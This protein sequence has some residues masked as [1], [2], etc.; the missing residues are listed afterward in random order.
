MLTQMRKGA[1]SWPSKI[2]LGVIALSFVGWGV[3][4]I[5]IN[6][7]E[8]T[9]AQVGDTEIDVFDLE[10]AYRTQIRQFQ[11]SGMQVEPGS[12]FARA[13]ANLSL[14]QLI[15]DTLEADNARAMGVTIAEDTLRADIAGNATFFNTEG[16]FD[17]AVFSGTLATSGL[18]EGRYL[19]ILTNQL[20]QS[21][22]INSIG[23]VPPP[24]DTLVDR[25]FRHRQERRV[26][27]IAVI[28]ND[29]LAPDPTPTDSALATYFAEHEQDYAAPE[30]R[31]ADYILVYPEDLATDVVIDETAV[32]EAYDSSPDAWIDPEQR[33][34]HQIPFE[35]KDA[36][37]AAYEL[38]RSG[39]DFAQVA[40]DSAG[41]DAES[42][43]LGWFTRVDL[44]AELSDPI[45]AVD[46]GEVVAPIESPLGGW[47][48][49]RVADAKAEQ[50]TPFE[51]AQPQIE[52]ALKLRAARETIFDLANDMDDIVASGTSVEETA[53][54]LQ[55]ERK[56]VER[57]SSIGQP[58][59]ILSLQIIPDAR[60]F[61]SELFF[62][63]IDFPSP[64]IETNDGGLLVVEVTAIA[65]AR[66]RTLDEVEDQVLVDWQLAEQSRLAQEAAEATA[67]AAGSS[68]DLAEAFETTFEV[69]EPF[70]RNQAPT[71]DN[72][73]LDTVEALFSASPGDTVVV[74]SAD[75]TAQVIAR[76]LDVVSGDPIADSEGH[77]AVEQ[78]LTNGLI[79]DVVDQ[80][81][82][83]M[84]N[85]TDVN[86]DED[87]VEQ[88]F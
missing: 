56:M 1:S 28:S 32:R 79:S 63:D 83:A 77:I 76:L 9:V 75:G 43:E 61:L 47:L 26:A 10:V 7:G 44:F 85:E 41:I 54:S 4:D 59:D 50:V 33:L 13:L 16:V 31:S 60:E 38:V 73:G 81:T 19:G 8:T 40:F 29:T 84:F 62:G 48:L 88:Y 45:F 55:L 72:V 39:S 3:G 21:Q 70:Q 17:P 24:P 66:M 67:A 74:N 22:Y 11:D 58:E 36:A 82:A 64:V 71:L 18:S 42:L 68:G 6:R 2:L 12:D 49:L 34:L 46:A 27:E 53:A 15:N 5:F 87:L 14:Q 35:T 65:P 52:Q 37:L 86:I 20:R 69:P 30:Y 23:A 80:N 51:E 25:I 78:S 57:V